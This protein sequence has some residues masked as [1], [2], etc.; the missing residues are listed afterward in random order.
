MVAVPLIH[1]K[2]E[3]QMYNDDF[4][5]DPRIDELREKTY[6][7][8]DKRYTKEYMEA[9]KRSIGNGVTIEFN[10]GTSLDEIA[11]DYPVGHARRRQEAIPLI[12]A[13][14]EK[15]LDGHF[16][17]AKKAQLLD[18]ITDHNKLTSMPVHDFIEVSDSHKLC[19]RMFG[20]PPSLLDSSGSRTRS[21]H[22]IVDK[23][24]DCSFSDSL[25][26]QE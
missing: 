16:D 20:S 2:L 5:A 6:C 3:P 8:E 17:D 9:D 25:L 10:D 4:A 1:G 18:L 7:V 22:F 26:C 15:H 23:I 13:K 21:A 19:T 24:Y 12:S 11:M 14:L